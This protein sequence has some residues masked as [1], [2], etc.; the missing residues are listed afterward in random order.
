MQSA[1]AI[2]NLSPAAGPSARAYYY[3]VYYP[4]AGAET[5]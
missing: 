2:L 5:D 3:A 4:T 1:N